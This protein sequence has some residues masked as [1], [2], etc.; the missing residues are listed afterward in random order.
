MSGS[1]LGPLR[2]SVKLLVRWLLYQVII[3][4]F[5]LDCG[6]NCSF[7]LQAPV[8]DRQVQHAEDRKGLWK[9][10]ILQEVLNF[11]SSV[12]GMYQ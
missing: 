6:Y 5:L 10:E 1:W 12:F 9:Q 11:D 3:K 2:K 7:F 4:Q 8:E